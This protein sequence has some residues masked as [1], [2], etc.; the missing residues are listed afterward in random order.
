MAGVKAPWWATI[1]VIVPIFS[2]F[3][4]LGM[5]LG[6]LLWWS[7]KENEVHL[8]PM[9]VRGNLS[10]FCLLKLMIIAGTS[11]TLEL[12]NSNLSSLPWEQLL[13]SVLPLSSRLS[14]GSDTGG[15]SLETLPGFR[16]Y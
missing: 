11:R 4:W 13:L 15:Q 5:L 14:A 12:I 7:V 3:V 16:R 10:S 1:Y 9:R 8:V 6:M 2:G